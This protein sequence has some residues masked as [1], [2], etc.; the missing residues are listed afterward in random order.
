MEELL[1]QLIQLLEHSDF[2]DWNIA[3]S[4]GGDGLLLGT[5]D[6]IQ[7]LLSGE[8][9]EDDETDDTDVDMRRR[10]NTGARRLVYTGRWY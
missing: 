10:T 6:F 8:E 2:P 5:D 7:S 3:A 9:G 4:E 1:K